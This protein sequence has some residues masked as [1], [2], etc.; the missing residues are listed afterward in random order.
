M[1][2]SMSICSGLIA[3]ATFAAVFAVSDVYI[4]NKDLY[5]TPHLKYA[6][7]MFVTA[8]TC[9]FMYSVLATAQLVEAVG[10]NFY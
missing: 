3:A 5:N 7:W 10:I 8:D 4:S 2:K 9:A 1:A 6:F